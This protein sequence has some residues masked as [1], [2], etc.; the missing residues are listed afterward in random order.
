M[1]K[2]FEGRFLLRF[3]DIDHTR[4]REEFYK[5]IEEDLTWMGISWDDDPVRQ[6]AR[7]PRYREAL[8]QLRSLGVLYPCF[9]TRRQI[10]EEIARMG[11]APHGP[12][13][14]LY[15]GT[16]RSLSAD[17]QQDHLATEAGHC[18]RLDTNK[19]S[20]LAGFLTFTDVTLGAQPVDPALL[21]DVVLARK[22]IATSY[23]LAVVVDDAAQGITHVTR[24]E[25][26]L[27]STHVHRLLQNLLSVPEPLYFHHEL[28]RDERGKRLATRNKALEVNIL[29][30][31]GQSAETLHKH[32][33]T[34]AQ[35]DT[36]N[37]DRAP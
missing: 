8:D 15:P 21:G 37:F 2:R 16:C 19:A 18:W 22:D 32:L 9:C 25:D 7:L 33:P 11:Q 29:R 28:V 12:E 4:V 13:G 24:G 31:T 23:H 14:P 36:L 27:A 26:L 34:F 6:S 20:E 5:G 10:N 1:A 3:E 35:L 30:Q 17:E